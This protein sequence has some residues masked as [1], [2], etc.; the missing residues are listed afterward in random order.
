M[1]RYVIVRHKESGRAFSMN[2]NY[3]VLDPDLGVI[4]APEKFVEDWDGW[5]TFDVPDWVTAMGKV[6]EIQYQFHAYWLF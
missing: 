4:I 6:Q 3:G 1:R 5:L 2:R